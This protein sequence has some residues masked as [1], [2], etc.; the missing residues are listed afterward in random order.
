MVLAHSIVKGPGSRADN[1][2]VIVHGILGAGM[3]LRSVARSLHELFPEWWFVLPDLR[4]HGKSGPSTPPHTVAACANDILLL[5]QE[6]GT[7]ARL[8]IGHSFGGKVVLAAGQKQVA[9]TVLMDTLPG[10]TQQN[11]ASRQWM[12]S[13]IGALGGVPMPLDSR[14]L[15]GPALGP[16]GRDP[17]FVGWMG[18]NLRRNSSGSG[19]SWRFDLHVI[20]ELIEDYWEQ[21]MGTWLEKGP[22]RA[23][24]LYGDRSERFTPETL[25]GLTR[26]IGDRLRPISDAG[27]WVHVD[28]PKGT[29]ARLAE[30]LHSLD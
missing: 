2:C 3:N 30:I 13:L 19:L 9:T 22:S 15:L 8:R 1:L 23:F 7:P 4:G 10:A 25:G 28:N 27:H 24:V 21:E 14:E 20:G 26:A 5:E 29:I 6:L 11:D 16:F 17:M 12:K 18:T